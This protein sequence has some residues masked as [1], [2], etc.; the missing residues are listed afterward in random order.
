MFTENYK[1]L[2]VQA[3]I[4]LNEFLQKF[5]RLVQLKEHKNIAVVVVN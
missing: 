5:Y 4:T 1:I 2:A 3:K